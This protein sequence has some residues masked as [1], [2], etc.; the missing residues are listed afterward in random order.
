MI[1]R[2]GTVAACMA[3]ASCQSTVEVGGTGGAGAGL[4]SAAGPACPS[5]PEMLWNGSR[6]IA[7]LVA[8]NDNLYWAEYLPVDDSHVYRMSKTGGQPVV[9]GAYYAEALAVGG[10]YLY[11]DHYDKWWKI[12]KVPVAGGASQDIGDDPGWH[13]D[14]VGKVG[15]F[16]VTSTSVV[17]GGSQPC[18][19]TVNSL[20]TGGGPTKQLWCEPAGSKCGPQDPIASPTD[21]L[22][23]GPSLV[24]LTR[25]S[26]PSCGPTT[27]RVLTLPT[28]GGSATTLVMEV[29]APTGFSVD[30]SAVYYAAGCNT[31]AVVLARVALA[32]GMPETVVSVTSSSPLLDCIGP[33]A[34][35]GD[36]VVYGQASAL[37]RVHKTGGTPAKIA[38]VSI[39]DADDLVVDGNGYYWN[40]DTR[41]MR[42]AK[43]H[44]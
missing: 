19:W 4:S 23:S 26:G 39:R 24:V 44:P 43:L 5:C 38:D 42:L 31:N 6:Q 1:L 14:S 36:F 15:H 7:H 35:D 33:I 10:G 41:I 13:P 9:M 11:T 18:G 37:W 17:F 28:W 16:S 34:V 8:D 12:T 40:H 3:F 30:S 25:L 32:G 21:V 20:P 2:G 27:G 22:V 29:S